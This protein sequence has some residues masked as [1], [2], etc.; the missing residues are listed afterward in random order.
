MHRCRTTHPSVSVMVR[1]TTGRM[2][3][4]RRP[5][6]SSW[7]TAW[8]FTPWVSQWPLHLPVRNSCAGANACAVCKSPRKWTERHKHFCRPQ[9]H[10]AQVHRR[11]LHAAAVQ[12]EGAQRHCWRRLVMFCT[13]WSFTVTACCASAVLTGRYCRLLCSAVCGCKSPS[14]DIA[15]WTM[16]ATTCW[17]TPTQAPAPQCTSRP[18]AGSAADAMRCLAIF[19]RPMLW[20]HR[21]VYI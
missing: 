1:T 17:R 19:L 11:G 15:G 14:C 13:F 9:P 10:Q 8:R 7:A 5:P 18:A 2:T 6:R 3:S 20:E 21:L 12:C 4:C 16:R